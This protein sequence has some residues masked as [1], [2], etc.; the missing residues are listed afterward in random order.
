MALIGTLT[1]DFASADGAKWVGYNGSTIA[2]SS[3][4]LSLTPDNT[5]NRAITSAT[6]YDVTGSAAAVKIVQ[7][8]S[9]QILTLSLRNST[10]VHRF[11]LQYSIGTLVFRESVNSVLSDTSIPYVAADHVWWRIREAGGTVFWETSVDGTTWVTRRSKTWGVPSVTAMLARLEAYTAS[12][13]TVAL[14]DDFN[15]PPSAP[16]SSSMWWAFLMRSRRVPIQPVDPA[17][18][19]GSA[20]YVSADGNDNS[21]GRTEGTAWKTITRAM[22]QNYTAGEALLFRRGDRFYGSYILKVPTPNGSARWTI[23]AYGSGDKP[24]IDAYVVLDVAGAWVQTSTNIWRIAM[25]NPANYNG[26][27]P[28]A[29]GWT[30]AW[31]AGHLRVGEATYGVLRGSTAALAAQWEFFGADPYLYIYSVGNPTT[32]A[33]ASGGLRAAI[34]TNGIALRSN[35]EIRDLEI[36]GVGR[37]AIT[38]TGGGNCENIVIADCHIHHIGGTLLSGYPP[39]LPKNGNGVDLWPP[40]NGGVVENNEIDNI[41]DV[42]CTIQGDNGAV[43]QNLTFRNNNIHDCGQAVEIF[44][45][46]GTRMVNVAFEDNTCTNSGGGW[47]GPVQSNQERRTAIL[48]YP[49]ETSGTGA[50]PSVFIR[51][52]IFNGCAR[53]YMV[54]LQSA[55]T[56][57][58]YQ[59]TNNDIRMAA[60][61]NINYQYGYTI[62]QYAA[63]QAAT[64]FEAGSTFTVL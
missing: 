41:Y 37:N 4:Q 28:R 42:A 44:Q 26:N 52:N 51:R 59:L 7:L 55:N 13:S 39:P 29:G 36:T 40:F 32:V 10:G 47:G 8:G 60:G 6:T 61:T 5:F 57:L 62:E 22:Q 45:S 24:I 1:D 33:A 12:G 15:S 16:D 17:P 34:E 50:N 48:A 64:G 31:N 21:D 56:M 30:Y 18:V 19:W 11:D 54:M 2:V 63:Y 20:Y 9:S 3:G 49:W 46:Y 23:G 53:H 35:T 43:G 27:L 58:G 38:S 14:L 25:N